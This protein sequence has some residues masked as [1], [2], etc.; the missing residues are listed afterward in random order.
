MSVLDDF[1]S[2]KFA[3][4]A[5]ATSLTSFLIITVS[6]IVINEWT[7]II[8]PPRTTTEIDDSNGLNRIIIPATK[9][10]IPSNNHRYQFA[11]LSLTATAMLMTLIL[12]RMIQI[13]SAIANTV[14]NIFGIAIKIRP[15]MIDSIPDI[16][17]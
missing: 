2:L 16:M 10:I 6:A 11:T 12:D 8:I 14:G 7:I 3:S 17:P 4:M 13:P 5:F 9:S 15:T 1:D